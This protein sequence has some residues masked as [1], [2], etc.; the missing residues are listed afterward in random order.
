MIRLTPSSVAFCTTKSM[1]SPRE[2]P[3]DQVDLQRR[4]GLGLEAVAQLQTGRVPVD[5]GDR[6]GPFR[7]FAVEDT[8]LVP[9][10]HTQRLAEVSCPIL[11]HFHIGAV[12]QFAGNK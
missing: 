12:D 6:S 9:G 4:L 7:A 11:L 1:R 2:T 8:E 10:S 3:L 5:T